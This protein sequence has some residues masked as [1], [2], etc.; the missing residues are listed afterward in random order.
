MKT[1]E[2]KFIE[3]ELATIQSQ[4]VETVS[5]IIT[6]V[7]FTAAFTALMAAPGALFGKFIT[8]AIYI[9]GL[10]SAMVPVVGA[11]YIVD[12][13]NYHKSL[14]KQ[15]KHLEAIYEKGLKRSKKLDAAR[16][17]KIY[18][19]EDEE[20]EIVPKLKVKNVITILSL[21][22]SFITACGSLLVISYPMM[23]YIS[24][25]STLIAAIS[26]IA[27]A[28]DMAKL[29]ELEAEIENFK[30]NIKLSSVCA[31]EDIE[32][33]KTKVLEENTKGYAS[34]K[35]IADDE[36]ME[37]IIKALRTSDEEVIE[38][39]MQYIKK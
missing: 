22:V 35:N 10:L 31:R 6:G 24:M 30:N 39:P 1:K 4:K 25:I 16:N 17:E 23:P 29:Y 32:K 9:F 18:E 3:R 21:I 11:N 37:D 13:I 28:K 19:L 33:E 20:N 27:S 12:K 36:T 15:E 34:G 5:N 8:E 26:T 38:K 7:L 2:N 14:S